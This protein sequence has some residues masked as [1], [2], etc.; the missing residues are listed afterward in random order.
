VK[1]KI[2][3][4][5]IFWELLG[6]FALCLAIFSFVLLMGNILQMTELV[7]N[8]G[9]KLL[10][11]VK[12]SFYLFPSLFSMTVPMATMICITIGFARLSSDSEITAMKA[13]GISLQQM[14]PPVIVLSISAWLITFFLTIYGAPWGTGMFKNLLYDIARAKASI[15]IKERVF[16]DDFKGY[17]LYVN[18]VS[19]QGD[20][21]TGVLISEKKTTDQSR[22]IIAG[23]GYI[24]P[25]DRDRTMGLHLKNGAIYQP[26]PG[27]NSLQTVR[28]ET[29]NLNLDITGGGGG[30]RD[31][32]RNSE[33]TIK[34]LLE[35]I[36]KVKNNKFEP[37]RYFYAL[38]DFHKRFSI[39]FACLVFGL[40]GVPLGLQ[41][42]PRGKSH[43]FILGL[44]VILIYYALFSFAEVLGKR[45]KV[46]VV[47]VLWVPNGVIGLL[48]I[49]FLFTTAREKQ[50]RIIQWVDALMDHT[51]RWVRRLFN[52]NA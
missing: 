24:L 33:L 40:I 37:R 7:I 21:M 46:P 35:K 14:L 20:V 15:A 30:K 3:H 18:K 26:N 2:F 49:Y 9:V 28:F 16:I 19:V 38:V 42:K 48:G 11:M 39:P 5:Y 36:E 47:P 17:V 43:G 1:F 45:G 44:G 31:N 6:P 23:K 12:L 29:Y 22:I 8:K 13:S 52:P 51:A 34:E 27:K 50:I 4:R 32:I 41:T 10:D 25:N